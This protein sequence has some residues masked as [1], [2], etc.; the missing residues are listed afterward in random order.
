MT[1]NLDESHLETIFSPGGLLAQVLPAYEERPQ[2]LEMA[3]LVW[4]CLKQGSH[5]LVE[6]GTGVGKSLA[7]LLPAAIWALSRGERV[8]VSTHTINL[9]EQLLQKDIPAVNRVLE[10]LHAPPLRAVLVKGRNNY[11]CLRRLDQEVNTREQQLSLGLLANEADLATKRLAEWAGRPG[12]S[13]DRADLPFPVPAEVWT[14]VQ[15]DSDECVGEKCPFREECFFRRARRRQ[16]ESHLLLTNH[17]LLCADLRVRRE[18]GGLGVLAS[19][20]VVICDEAHHLDR[21]AA[22]HLGTRLTGYRFAWLVQAVEDLLGQSRAKAVLSERTLRRY[23]EVLARVRDSS[24]RFFNDLRDRLFSASPS[25]TWRP[26]RLR[27]PLPGYQEL[28]TDLVRLADA[29][30]QIADMGMSEEHSQLAAN[31][32]SRCRALGQELEQAATLG[33]PACAYWLEPAPGTRYGGVAL[34][35]APISV[36]EALAELLF[37]RTRS[38]ILTSATLAVGGDFSYTASS[39]GLAEYEGLVLGSP[40]DYQQQALLCVPEDAAATDPNR[41]GY[42]SYVA[43]KVREIVSITRG[44]AFVLFT[45]YQAMNQVYTEV[46]PHLEEMGYTCLKQGDAPRDALLE[47]FRRD[48]GSVLFGV[49]SFWEGVDVPGEALSCVIIA[50]LPFEVPD[51]PLVEARCEHLRSLGKD[52]FREYTLPRAAIKLKQGFG[53]LIR[54]RSDRGAVVILDHRVA[55]RYYGRY[56][57]RALPPVRTTTDLTDVAMLLDH[58]P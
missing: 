53:R 8:V 12:A 37:S 9:Q 28:L 19:H 58:S 36:A 17:A 21:V 47:E 40:F 4:R 35:S 55:T 48:T 11:L 46:A 50:R 1:V 44:R 33:D 52:P 49:D 32:A 14:K 31:Q 34:C 38:V 30:D 41:P 20:E 15:S 7:Y 27:A 23:E 25:G 13:G 57:M 54:T 18:T 45:S 51:E 5:G 6:A 29:L 24:T 39:L 3:R 22:D 43:D 26:L 16:D 10:Q 2:Q 42:L 56:L